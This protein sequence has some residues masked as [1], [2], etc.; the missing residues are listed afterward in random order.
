MGTLVSSIHVKDDTWRA[1]FDA[2]SSMR[3]AAGLTNPRIFRSENDDKEVI[4]MFDVADEAKAR[5]FEASNELQ[6]G[7]RKFGVTNH[8]FGFL[9]TPGP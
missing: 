1:G 8:R 9:T 6:E 4:I 5:S 2:A 3:N 7:M